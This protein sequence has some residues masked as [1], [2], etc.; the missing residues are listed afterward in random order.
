MNFPKLHSLSHISESTRKFGTPDNVDTEITEHQHRIDVKAPY[1]RTNKRDPLPQ[2][3]KFVER[4]TAFE[5]KLGH[6]RTTDTSANTPRPI[7]E[8]YRH[9]SSAIP[10]GAIHINEAS[11]LFNI[12]D[13]EL[14]VQTFFHDLR[15]TG[16][17]Y[18]HRV[19]KRN[20]PKLL[21]PMVS[22]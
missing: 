22:S 21:N 11:K 12:C 14:A 3:V 15:Y 8:N 9:L 1:R 17:G 7:M 4:R 6:I 10:G 19:R 20:L 5:D 16:E 18:R 2:V 13:L